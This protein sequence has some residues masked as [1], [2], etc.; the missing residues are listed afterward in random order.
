MGNWEHGVSVAGK[1]I[2]NLRHSYDT[3]VLAPNKLEKFELLHRVEEAS[4]PLGLRLN[5]VKCCLMIMDRSRTIALPL[6]L[7][8]DIERRDSFIYLGLHITNKEGSEPEIKR[9]IGRA[10]DVLS[11]LFIWKNHKILKVTQ[12]KPFN[13]LKVH[14]SCHSKSRYEEDIDSG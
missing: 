10:R 4:L 12:V 3:I 11:T 7:V 13:A 8:D 5:R 1:R 6:R 14:W 9:R 2:T